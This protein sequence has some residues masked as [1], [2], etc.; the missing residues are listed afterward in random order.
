MLAIGGCS[1]EFGQ[2]WRSYNTLR[3]QVLIDQVRELAKLSARPIS[4]ATAAGPA[5]PLTDGTAA[6]PCRLPN[7]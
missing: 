4:D 2:V 6:I 1:T 7:S 5:Q 3:E